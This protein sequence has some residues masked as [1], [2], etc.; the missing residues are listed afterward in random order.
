[1]IQD[2][3][4]NTQND[5]HDEVLNKTDENVSQ[6]LK[7]DQKKENQNSSINIKYHSIYTTCKYAK[8]NP[9]QF[10]EQA[11]VSSLF[12]QQLMYFNSFYTFI[13][14]YFLYFSIF[15]KFKICDNILGCIIQLVIL[16][17][18]ALFEFFRLN[19]GYS[20]NINETF[21]EFVSF[22]LL[23]I[24]N[25]IL[26][27]GFVVIAQII[28]K[29][30]FPIEVICV[31]IEVLFLVLE[32]IVCFSSISDIVKA[33]L[34]NRKYKKQKQKNIEL[35]PIGYYDDE[36]DDID[37]KKPFSR[38]NNPNSNYQSGDLVSNYQ[39]YEQN[40]YQTNPNMNY[41]SNYNN[42]EQRDVSRRIPDENYDPQGSNYV[43]YQYNPGQ[44]N[45]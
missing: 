37:E 6:L 38:I 14:G 36:I 42:Y 25:I 28:F 4:I 18:W 2:R 16:T 40:A 44:R 11:I 22:I 43:A 9:T 19:N 8:P 7:K 20:G 21:P 13:H 29:F 23:T 45:Y 26:T 31:V 12:L 1:M 41:N 24:A 34:L 39:N 32:L 35:E 27:I 5:N 3:T 10:R 17:I 15:Y 33:Q 30:F